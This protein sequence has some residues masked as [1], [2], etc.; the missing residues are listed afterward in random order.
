MSETV[1]DTGDVD[2]RLTLAPF[3]MLPRD[4]TVRLTPGRFCRATLT[5]EGP[6]AITVRWQASRPE[7]HMRSTGPGGNWL[8]QQAPALLGLTDDITGFAP[9]NEPL[10]TIWAQRRG[11]RIGASGTIWHDLAF[12]IVQQRVARSSAAESWRR[13]VEVLGS[14]IG[15]GEVIAPPEPSVI[16][17]LT[18]D[19][20]HPF[21]I[22]R[23]RGENLISA[24]RFV[25]RLR[26]PAS[27]ERDALLAKLG[28]VRGVG[29]WTLSCLSTFTFGAA[30]AVIVGDA[31]IPSIVTWLLAREPR[32]SD[33]RMLE[34]LE[35]Y[36][37]HRYRVIR[38]AFASG[39]KPPRRAP[40][41]PI[42]RIEGR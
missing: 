10:R 23:R 30:D 12:F 11:D 42:H 29:R 31:G 36:R 17:R 16:A 33:A 21:G 25:S 4:P 28:A 19:Q 26:E 38:L 13:M 15:E 35:P 41:A 34:L 14:P 40:H 6:G 37:P 7:A 2:L 20:L 39:V 5:P 32:G 1:L 3:G 9:S 27:L 18:Y 8:M 22:E 24:A